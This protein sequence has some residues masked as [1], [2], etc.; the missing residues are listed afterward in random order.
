[1]ILSKWEEIEVGGTGFEYP[2]YVRFIF[3]SKLKYKSSAAMI[4]ENSKSWSYK[5]RYISNYKEE[6]FVARDMSEIDSWVIGTAKT[7]EI[8][9]L[10]ADLMAIDMGYD[11]ENPL[12]SI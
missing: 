7:K 2:I 4:Y 1:M 10:H 6:E 12:I 8:A 9:M 5:I 11:L 3:I